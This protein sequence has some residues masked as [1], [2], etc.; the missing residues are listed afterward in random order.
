MGHFLQQNHRNRPSLSQPANATPELNG[1][2]N[3]SSAST[4]AS[5]SVSSTNSGPTNA[6]FHTT[7][8]NH[9]T[10]DVNTAMNMSA[11]NAYGYNVNGGNVNSSNGSNSINSNGNHIHQHQMG[12]ESNVSHGGYLP[13]HNI[14][15]QNLTAEAVAAL[16]PPGAFVTATSPRSVCWVDL[17]FF[18]N[19]SCIL[20]NIFYLFQVC[21]VQPQLN[22]VR[23]IITAMETTQCTYPTHLGLGMSI[24]K[25]RNI[26]CLCLSQQNRP[27]RLRIADGD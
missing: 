8:H 11:S 21:R 1:K 3:I 7:R 5:S 20:L 17:S 10:I 4:S 18:V 24:V 12:M 16:P 9:T 6:N 27:Y 19:F 13:A 22:L 14:P 25:N 15:P 26:S 2:A 23:K